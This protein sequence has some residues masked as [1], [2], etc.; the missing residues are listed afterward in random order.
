[1]AR[2]LVIDDD[3]S[4]LKMMK[5]MLEKAGHTAIL[6]SSGREGIQAAIDEQPDLAIVDVMMP[7]LSGYEVCRALREESTTANIPLLILTARAQPMDRQMAVDAGADGFVTKPITRDDLIEHVAK[8]LESGATNFPVA[9]QSPPPAPSPAE[10]PIIDGFIEQP[11]PS[12]AEQPQPPPA[13]S[14]APSLPTLPVIAVMGLR[15]G[16]GTTTVAVNLGLGMMQHGRACIVDL[17]DVP[18][19][20]AVQLKMLPPAATWM[21][22]VTA[23]PQP[24]PTQIGSS[25][26]M[27][28]AAGVAVLAAPTTQT[29]ERLSA[30][31]LRHVFTVLSEGFKRI[32]VDLPAQTD[33]TSQAVL[34]MAMHMVLVVSDDLAILQTAGDTLR[35]IHALNLNAAQHIVLNRTRPGGVSFQ[36]AQ[37]VLGGTISFELPYETTQTT[38]TAQGRPLVMSAPAS[39]FSQAVL[40]LSRML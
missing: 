27:H 16:S 28:P 8:L 2:I 39:P 37:Q 4:L 38:A 10:A 18:G 22:L 17:G 21:N 20:V 40:L 29:P 32:V 12:T 11:A 25:L 30:E 5:L 3:R 34:Q 33:P 9:A 7:E 31:T 24:D 1:M 15:G 35:A 14:G 19:H 26:M 23:G 36:E 13:P 6:T